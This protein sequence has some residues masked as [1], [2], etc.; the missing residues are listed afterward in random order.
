LE[1]GFNPVL[2]WIQFLA[3]SGLTSLM[4]LHD[5]L[6]KCIIAL[7]ARTRLAWVYTGVNDT[8]WL[9]RGAGSSL[10]DGTL[11]LS[12]TKLTPGSFLT[13][14][15]MPLTVYDPICMDQVARMELLRMMPTLDDVDITAVQR[16]D[17]TRGVQILGADAAGNQ[18]SRAAGGCGSGGRVVSSQSGGA[19]GGRG[20]ST[21]DARGSHSTPAL[22]KG[23][24][25]QA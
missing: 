9:E 6:L 2:E 13:D 3:E 7:Q 25:K 4:V 10:D 22:S 17:Q 12:L 16:G 23:K 24:E 20:S 11:A 15:V 1:L 14:L 19:T 18:G 21:S 5:Y 8:T